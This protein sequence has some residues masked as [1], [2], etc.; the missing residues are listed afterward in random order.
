VDCI[1]APRRI[2][3]AP[4]G[5]IGTI[6][7]YNET[8]FDQSIVQQGLPVELHTSSMGIR[9][10][11]PSPYTVDDCYNA[12]ATRAGREN[13]IAGSNPEQIEA[14]RNT[15]EKQDHMAKAAALLCAKEAIDAAEEIYLQESCVTDFQFLF[16][17][18]ASVILPTEKKL[19][20]HFGK[21]KL[22]FSLSL[23]LHVHSKDMQ[24]ELRLALERNNDPKME[25]A[26]LS[27]YKERLLVITDRY[28]KA[29]EEFEK[30]RAI[31][32]ECAVVSGL[33]YILLFCFY[34]RI[35]IV[36]F[37]LQLRFET[38]HSYRVVLFR[39]IC[40]VESKKCST[41]F[42][43]TTFANFYLCQIPRNLSTVFCAP[44]AR[45]NLE[46]VTCTLLFNLNPC[47]LCLY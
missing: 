3:S 21:S 4:E 47:L 42:K 23:I 30:H 17:V 12:H 6:I 31:A 16:G 41:K 9:L 22:I 24:E 19:I 37:I 2:A 20:F 28:E 36:I 10:E 14:R 40:S 43:I 26:I 5:T 34:F 7:E 35:F 15:I 27:S 38:F 45:I 25:A 32:K 39:N 1:G 44:F 29:Q 18:F 33:I 8:D 11:Y 13:S 46:S